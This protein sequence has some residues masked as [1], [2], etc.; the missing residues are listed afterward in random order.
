PT[1]D[2]LGH[3]IRIVEQSGKPEWLT[4]VGVMPS[5]Y[6]LGRVSANGDHFPPELLTPFWQQHRWTSAS[7]AL[8]GPATVANAITVRKV[9]T[10]L[11]P[12]LPV[13]ATAP[14]HEVLNKPVWPVR[15]FGTLF[16]IFGFVSL[17]LAA[18]G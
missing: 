18:I 5:L 13:Y 17:V 16:V 9:I 10:P 15:V 3:R 11:D 2:P 4:I 7:I 14:M 8:R 6:A 1:A 12:D